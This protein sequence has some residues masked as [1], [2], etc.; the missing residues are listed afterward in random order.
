MKEERLVA[1]G[2]LLGRSPDAALSVR[3]IM[4]KCRIRAYTTALR[5]LH[6]YA[7]LRKVEL[8]STMR[9][10]GAAGPLSRVYW[11]KR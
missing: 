3:S 2:K 6:A 10:E 4:K 9:R 8:R 1:V 7:A 11:V 5:R